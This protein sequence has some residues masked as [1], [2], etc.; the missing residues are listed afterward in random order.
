MTEAYT[1]LTNAQRFYGQPDANNNNVWQ[2]GVQVPFNFELISNTN[3]ESSATD[4]KNSITGWV[5]ALEA[6]Q[7]QAGNIKLNANWVVSICSCFLLLLTDLFV[8]ILNQ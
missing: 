5:G 6:L 2:N 3:D 7:K 8:A 1:T 4:F